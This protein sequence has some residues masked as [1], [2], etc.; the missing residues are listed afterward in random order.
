MDL[1]LGRDVIGMTFLKDFS[2][3]TE[4]KEMDLIRQVWKWEYRRLLLQRNEGGVS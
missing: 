2:F 1:E 4:E 3:C